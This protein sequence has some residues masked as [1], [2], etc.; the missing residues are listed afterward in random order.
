MRFIALFASRMSTLIVM[1]LPFFTSFL[2]L[3][4]W[5]SNV[6]VLWNP[7]G[8]SM[9]SLST[10]SLMCFS[11]HSRYA[12]AVGLFLCT[13]G[14]NDSSMLNSISSLLNDPIP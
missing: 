5:K 6:V 9:I 2:L 14:V 12:S 13:T 8:P 1:L 4:R 11:T 3:L 10:S 7:N